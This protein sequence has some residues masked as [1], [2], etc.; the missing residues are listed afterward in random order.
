M[1]LLGIALF[2]FYSKFH[3]PHLIN[4]SSYISS[5]SP[6]IV[7]GALLYIRSNLFLSCIKY[8]LQACT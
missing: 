4:I 3:N 5:P 1:S 8:A 2:F 7:L 6:L